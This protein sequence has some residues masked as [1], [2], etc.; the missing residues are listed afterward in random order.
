M[1]DALTDFERPLVR[2]S[3]YRT[4]REESDSAAG[5]AEPTTGEKSLSQ[6]LVS[7]VLAANSGLRIKTWRHRKRNPAFFRPG[8]LQFRCFIASLITERQFM[9]DQAYVVILLG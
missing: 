8:G 2:R 1:A 6:S 7:A 4:L 9:L 3:L 5:C